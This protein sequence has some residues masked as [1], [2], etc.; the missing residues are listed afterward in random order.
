MKKVIYCLFDGSGIAGLPWAEDGHTVYCFNADSGNHGE[1][2]IKMKHENIHYVNMW[3]DKDFITKCELLGLPPTQMVIGFPDC[4]LF[5]QSGS[6]HERGEDELAYALA[7]AK[8][9]E[10][11]G[12]HFQAPWMVENP[13]GKLS[14]LWR[15]PDFYF[16]PH[17]Y[18]GLMKAGDLPYHEKM[19]KYDGYTKK[20]CIWHGNGFVEP[21]KNPGPINIGFFWGWKYLGGKSA[22]TKQLRSLT[23]RGFARAVYLANH[24]TK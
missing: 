4:T 6:Q 3:I 2:H 17:E 14:S 16:N 19:P 20:T 11:V 21:V 9:V 22:K 13:V 15:K 5:S 7:N 12:N 18:G 23:P 10:E 8:L 1:Y 24:L